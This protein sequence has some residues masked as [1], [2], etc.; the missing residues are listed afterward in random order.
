MADSN[1]Y[2]A[3]SALSDETVDAV[4]DLSPPR[5][6][7][8]ILLFV[9]TCFLLLLNGQ[10][11]TNAV[12]VLAF[13]LASAGLWMRFRARAKAKTPTAGKSALMIHA[14]LFFAFAATLPNAYTK[15]RNFNDA[16]NRIKTLNQRRQSNAS[17][18]SAQPQGSASM[19]NRLERRATIPHLVN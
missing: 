4:I 18:N 13:V 1:P 2:S 7:S 14:I 8:C 10:H 5:L 9:G 16:V 12:F 19:P 17:D 3:P 11:F 15:Q 6:V